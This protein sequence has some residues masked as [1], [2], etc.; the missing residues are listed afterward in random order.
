MNASEVKCDLSTIAS[1]DLTSPMPFDAAAAISAAREILEPV[2]T[3][4]GIYPSAALGPLAEVCAEIADQGQLRPAMV[5][6]SLLGAASLLTQGLFNVQTMSGIKPL[7][8]F[9]LTLGDSGD[10]KSTAEDIA[11]R[12]VN[13]WQRQASAKY[14]SQLD[15]LRA[16][17][18]RA[19]KAEDNDRGPQSPYR[20]CRDATVEGLRRE[21]SEGV[22]SQ[23]IFTSEAAS[24]L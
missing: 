17:K 7:S 23:G 3:P 19:K 18:S 8:L 9:L 14:R 5:G 16:R 24:L 13:E 4:H 2:E 21:L 12:P 15:E 6:Q 22:I 20:I 11:L 1:L 10:G